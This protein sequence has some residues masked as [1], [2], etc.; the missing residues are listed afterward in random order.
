MHKLILSLV[1]IGS[2]V[3]GIVASAA[4]GVVA[5]GTD[6][7]REAAG[8]PLPLAATQQIY[9][10]TDKPLY[11]PGETIWFRA[12]LVDATLQATGGAGVTVQ[13]V[14][15]RGGVAVEKR[16]KSTAGSAHN[17]IALPATL[18]GGRY[19]LRVRSEAGA[20]EDRA[21]TISTYEVPRLKQTLEFVRRGY[22]AGDE[23][24]AALTVLRATGE[25]A[26]GARVTATI[27]VD[28]VTIARPGAIVT[29]TGIA[30]LR[31]RLPPTIERGDGLLTASVTDG[32]ATE[33]IQRR[34]PIQTGRV[35]IAFYPEGGDLVAGLA[36][37]VYFAATS[38]LGEPVDVRGRIVDE[39][40]KQVGTFSS[41]FRGR[42]A[43]ELA[44]TAGHSYVAIVDRPA[45]ATASIA[46]PPARDRGCV[47]RV[48]NSASPR[49]SELEIAVACTAEHPI[50]LLAALR[51]REV[52]RAHGTA[53]P[54]RSTFRVPLAAAG[55]GAVRLTLLAS[56][57]PTAERLVYRK[58][59]TDLKLT[60][61][62]DRDGHSPREPVSLAIETRD[63]SGRP[64]STDVAIAVVDDAVLALAGDRSA[65]ILARLY[66]EPEMPGQSIEDPNFYFSADPAAPAALDLVLGTQG[67]R[68]FK[69]VP[70]Q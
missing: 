45:A 29:R 20:V 70:A 62:P 65:R 21:L 59:G 14:D 35:A 6:P 44:P 48:P 63:P 8:G 1:L 10:M 40:G 34:I 3:A 38:P 52:G 66:L 47:L 68:R 11:R 43:F 51:G 46:I 37:R 56:S 32:G 12:W 15:P 49:S 24:A 60:I 53:G 69:R 2:I 67:W 57:T 33:S 16:V 13:L 36:S 18:A 19:V 39:A 64:V 7:D 27:V 54:A 28:G 26:R 22:A 41:T 25:P 4:P 61:T 17:D 55:Q 42:G 5:T 31:F 30:S 50:E 9:V 58:L 23:V